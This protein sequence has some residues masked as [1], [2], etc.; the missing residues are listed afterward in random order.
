MDQYVEKLIE[1]GEKGFQVEAIIR[2]EVAVL[3]DQSKEL[4]NY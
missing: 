4:Q 3:I 1:A 2:K